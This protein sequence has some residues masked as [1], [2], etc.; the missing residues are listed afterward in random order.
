MSRE[1]PVEPRGPEDGLSEAPTVM[2]A[3]RGAPIG[4]LVRGMPAAVV[5]EAALRDRFGDP[6]TMDRQPRRCEAGCVAR[7]AFKAPV[8]GRGT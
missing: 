1:E 3:G 4:R 5:L 2:N 6:P 8:R 7:R